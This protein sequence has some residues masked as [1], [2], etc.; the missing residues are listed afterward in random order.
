MG[1]A[2]SIID[3]TTPKQAEV[4]QHAQSQIERL[5]GRFLSIWGEHD[6]LDRCSMDLKTADAAATNLIYRIESRMLDIRDE[7]NVI[8]DMLSYERPQTLHEISIML[9]A[10]EIIVDVIV[11]FPDNG[12]IRDTKDKKIK[13]MIKA[14]QDCLAT[15]TETSLQQHQL[16][17]NP[18][19]TALLSE[20]ME[21]VN[22][23]QPMKAA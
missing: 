2:D 4:R 13:R 22:G 18:E 3:T 20:A 9:D 23:N 7:G 11:D 8:Q 5:N 21:L 12:K 16:P 14:I 1:A 17:T 19:T 6:K 10:I 15:F